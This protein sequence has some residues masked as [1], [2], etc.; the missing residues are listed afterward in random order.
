MVAVLVGN[1]D[2]RTR[3]AKERTRFIASLQ[4][5]TP[6]FQVPH[7]G[8]IFTGQWPVAADH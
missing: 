6:V 3:G 7:Q 5:P 8:I 1:V 2:Y 4:G